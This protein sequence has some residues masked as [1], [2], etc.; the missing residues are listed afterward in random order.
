MKRMTMKEKFVSRSRSA[1]KITAFLVV[2]A[3]VALVSVVLSGYDFDYVAWYNKVVEDLSKISMSDVSIFCSD[4]SSRI[5]LEF[6]N[7]RSSAMIYYQSASQLLSEMPWEFTEAHR[8]TLYLA[9]GVVTTGIV[10]LFGL[11]KFISKMRRRRTAA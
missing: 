7:V 5:L 11:N 6:S 4:I 8:E 3:F 10:T 9:T 1:F 2:F